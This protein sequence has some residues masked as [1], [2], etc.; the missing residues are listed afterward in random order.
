MYGTTLF[1]FFPVN[2]VSLVIDTDYSNWAVLVQCHEGVSGEP[3]FLST[4]LLSRTRKV[5]AGHWIKAEKSVERAKAAAPYRL[6]TIS[7][8]LANNK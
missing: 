6:V 7:K 1:L 4:R 8:N 5:E 3:A 2:L